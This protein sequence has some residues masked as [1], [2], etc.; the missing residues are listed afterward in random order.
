M[1]AQQTAV[2]EP[3][4]RVAACIKACEGI[5]IEV[6]EA[7]A[8]GGLPWH[9]AD[10]IETRVLQSELLSALQALHVVCLNCDLETEAERPTEEQ[11]TAAMNA[12]EAVIAKVHGSAA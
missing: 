4:R 3:G 10:Q 2:Q 1:S 5:P 6:L 7:N 12:A 8:A 11:Y 9:V